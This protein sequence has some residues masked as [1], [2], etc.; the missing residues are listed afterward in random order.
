MLP[1]T[2]RDFL[3]IIHSF[4]SR[5]SSSS[6]NARK[7]RESVDNAVKIAEEFGIEEEL[8]EREWS[9]LSGGEAQRMSLAVSLGIEGAE[10][11]LLDGQFVVYL[12][13]SPS[14]LILFTTEPTS[15]L[16]GDTIDIVERYLKELPN[17]EDSSIKAIV[18]VTHSEDQAGRVGNRRLRVES[19]T[20]NEITDV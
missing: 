15:A 9:T 20:I 3:S 14:S 4:A 12:Y 7:H 11:L 6:S 1:G 17:K 18:W 2:P 10:V 13:K 19:G 16:D 8:W 5:Q